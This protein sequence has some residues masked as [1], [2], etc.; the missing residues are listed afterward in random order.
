M[1]SKWYLFFL[2]TIFSLPIISFGQSEAE[3]YEKVFGKKLKE[4]NVS[5]PLYLDYQRIGK[6][7]SWIKGDTI[8]SIKGTDLKK[9]LEE[10]LDEKK[11]SQFES[12]FKSEKVLFESLSSGI[13]KIKYDPIKII[14]E[15][16]IPTEYLKNNSNTFDDQNIPRWAKNPI[17]PKY[18]SGA[19]NFSLEED[20]GH[21][22]TEKSYFRS[23]IYGQFNIHN[24][25]LEWDAEYQGQ[26]KEEGFN[27]G[28]VRI[29]RDWPTH[30]IRGSLGDINPSITNGQS[31]VPLLG[32][33]INRDYSLAPYK[34]IT[35]INQKEFILQKRSLV[36]FFVNGS[37]IK[38]E[39][40]DRGRYS[41]K[42][43]PLNEGLNDIEVLVRD[44]FG[45][46]KR[47]K[48]KE[49]SS[50][51]LLKDGL[52][53]FDMTLGVPS[54]QESGEIKYNQKEYIFSTYFEKGLN[55][56]LTMGPNFQ[57][58]KSQFN[59]GLNATLSSTIGVFFI[60]D[61]AS[62]IKNSKDGNKASLGYRLESYKMGPLGSFS[63]VTEVSHLTPFYTP[64]NS[65]LVLNEI[66]YQYRVLISKPFS[67]GFSIGAGT[68]VGNNRFDGP[69][70]LN[71]NLNLNKRMFKDMNLSFYYGRSR[72]TSG[73]WS[74]NLYAFLSF[75]LPEFDQSGH[76]FYDSPNEISRAAWNYYPRNELN[77]VSVDASIEKNKDR[78][79]G[80]LGINHKNNV[81]EFKARETINN[82]NSNSSRTNLKLLSSI[83]FVK[84]AFVISRPTN[85]SFALFRPNPL[86]KE[87][88][89]QNRLEI[90]NNSLYEVGD[91]GSAGVLA[92]PNM[93][94]Y[95]FY[96]INLD[97]RNLTPGTKLEAEEYILFPGYKS[98]H[99]IEVSALGTVLLRGRLVDSKNHPLSLTTGRIE[100]P[101][102]DSI[103]LFTNRSG[104]FV[105]DGLTAGNYKVF[106]DDDYNYEFV[107]EEDKRGILMMGTLY[108]LK[109]ERS[110]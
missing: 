101:K 76:I 49:V 22:S 69:N 14:L 3:Q 96:K 31:S 23:D 47:I 13:L 107:I 36:S 67:S 83:L 53:K 20:I 59:L 56:Y 80:D 108:P 103:P 105:A 62:R 11:L 34:V 9:P 102:G 104:H 81:F 19:L 95:S 43:L 40:L 79:V 16:V 37:L 5:I 18:P 21:Q 75:F 88:L 8:I 61:N 99:L 110:L 26:K 57:Y 45:A 71:Y 63:F 58:R 87:E 30:A 54:F 65:N 44:D 10:I 38:E 98:G 74:T 52:N 28:P 68:S 41:L 1:K 29:I 50:N 86:L 46:E 72:T 32:F 85:G 4:I 90:K 35:P 27:R 25:V 91:F 6:I 73:D 100:T 66:D 12:I 106:M 64:F 93:R 70:S 48:F 89:S 2:F 15:L 24:F 94:P 42:D 17:Y 97:T 7:S 60:E 109:N 55:R 82:G 92:F 51:N 33:S 78:N 84:D 39:W 77:N